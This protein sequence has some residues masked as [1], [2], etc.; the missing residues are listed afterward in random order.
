MGTETR[1]QETN[2]RLF[3]R[4]LTVAKVFK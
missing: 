1:K 2:S 3:S 4:L